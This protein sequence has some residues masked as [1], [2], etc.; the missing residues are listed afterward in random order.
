MYKGHGYYL[1]KLGKVSSSRKSFTV[2]HISAAKLVKGDK[3][4]FRIVAYDKNGKI[5]EKSVAVHVAAA[6][7]KAKNYKK[8][9]VTSPKN[10]RLTLKM[11]T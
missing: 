1:K 3:Y 4:K 2:K 9:K 7:T 11:R 6:G 10:V 8:V 5:L